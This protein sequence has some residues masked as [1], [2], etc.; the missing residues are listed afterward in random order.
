MYRLSLIANK[1]ELKTSVKK[2]S[3][4]CFNFG[5]SEIG[6]K[7]DGKAEMIDGNSKIRPPPYIVYL[8]MNTDGIFKQKERSVFFFSKHL[9]SYRFSAANETHIFT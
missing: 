3:F 6:L 4:F 2:L 7:L 1:Q 5:N 9:I 8:K